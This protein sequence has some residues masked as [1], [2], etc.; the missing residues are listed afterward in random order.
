MTRRYPV[1]LLCGLILGSS[2]PAVAQS[3][4][5]RVIGQAQWNQPLT[6][7]QLNGRISS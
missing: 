1:V 4:I 6:L 5:D 2:A 3:V 7:T